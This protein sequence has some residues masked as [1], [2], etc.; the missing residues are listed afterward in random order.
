VDALIQDLRLSWIAP[1]YIPVFSQI[2]F[3]E[4]RTSPAT[5]CRSLNLWTFGPPRR[6]PPRWMTWVLA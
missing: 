2:M 1:G 5:I 6:I 4:R 3:E